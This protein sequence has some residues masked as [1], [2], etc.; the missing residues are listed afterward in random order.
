MTNEGDWKGGTR[1]WSIFRKDGTL[2][3][4]SGNSLERAIA[5]MGHYPDHRSHTKGVELESVEFATFGGVPMAFV[6]SERAS[7][8]AVYDL[9]DPA[10]PVL[11]QI[12]P[13]G[14]SPEGIVAIPERNLLVTAN[15]V[16]LREDGGARR[17]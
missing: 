1:T 13:S 3:W 17:M 7:V 14:I 6:V 8:V 10:N 4:D 9:T 15:E 16:D 12:L 5:A 2:V 11:K